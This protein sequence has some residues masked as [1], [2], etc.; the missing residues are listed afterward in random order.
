MRRS[1]SP[2]LLALALVA[3]ILAS[4][5]GG[6]GSREGEGPEGDTVRI[7]AGADPWP[8][9]GTGARS[10][11][12]AYPLNLNVYEPLVVL[13]PDLSPAPGLAERWELVDSDRTWRFHLRRDVVFHD[14]RP[15]TAEDVVWTWSRQQEAR[16]VTTVLDTLA[17]DSVRKVDD[18]TVDFT[19]AVT[20]MRLPEQLAHPQAAVLPQGNNFD[21]SPPV[22]T[23]PFRVVGYRQNANAA[24]ERFDRYWG[25]KAGVERV[26]VSFLAD[27]A[28]RVRALRDGDADLVIDP[29]ADAVR[30]LATD[31]DFK[32][33]R[34][35][36]G[37]THV[38]YVNKTGVAPF[39]LGGD[40]VVRRAVS[41]AIDREAYVDAV[42]HGNG[43]PGRWMV[44][45]QVLGRSADLVQPVPADPAEARRL[46]DQAGW[47]PGPDGVRTRGGRRLDLTLIGWADVPAAAFDFVKAR[48]GE[49]G[50]TVT[51]SPAPDQATFR[52]LYRD[53]D[54]DLD[55]ELPSQ[56]D[57]NPAF[58]PVLRMYSRNP[59]AERFAPGSEFDA[60]A[61][62]VA[63][64]RSLEQAQRIAAEMIDLL[65][66]RENIVITLASAQRVYAMANEVGL[67][68]PHPSL[69]NQNWASLTR[70]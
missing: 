42:L 49:V 67:R 24:F 31:K 65:T 10:T 34:T 27:A 53:T 30:G 69:A 25:P 70:S 11:T 29:P 55:L 59:G 39:D 8:A 2:V 52:G 56:N 62:A 18:F 64:T 16:K 4:A 22:G 57:A 32:V 37:R 40:P 17:P 66:A 15:F 60:K 41:L 6:G 45:R 3:A 1:R 36:P 48:L 20:N 19:P 38:I 61:E 43:E 50:V 13:A 44:P 54:F 63:R 51:T 12:F 33:V 23:G 28:Q 7:V 46:L 5:C 58:L 9:E 35:E 21:S 14:G 26:E 47:V 68:E